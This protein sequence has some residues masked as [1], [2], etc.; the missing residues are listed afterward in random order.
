MARAYSMAKTTNGLMIS[1]SS[2]MRVEAADK[3]GIFYSELRCMLGLPFWRFYLA[4]YMI[5]H[6]GTGAIRFYIFPLWRNKNR[7]SCM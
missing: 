6:N 5:P 1:G 7:S 4:D 2:L 3:N